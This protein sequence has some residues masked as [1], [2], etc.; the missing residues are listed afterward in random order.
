MNRTASFRIEGRPEPKPQEEPEAND[1]CVSDS[2]FHT[3]QIPILRGREFSRQDSDQGPPV[4]AVNET[5]AARYWP[6]EDAIGKRMRFPGP[7]AEP[8]RVVVAVVGN[9]RSQLDTPAPAEMY[10][11]LHQRT[12]NTMALGL[13]LALAIG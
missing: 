8:W 3:M 4:L 5:L 2:Y 6:G 13:P 12:E 9:V 11:P 10:F 1:R 7:S